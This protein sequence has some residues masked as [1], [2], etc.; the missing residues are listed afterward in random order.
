[1]SVAELRDLFATPVVKVEIDLKISAQALID[2]AGNISGAGQSLDTHLFQR[3]AYEGLLHAV[4][5]YVTSFMRSVLGIDGEPLFTQAWLNRSVPGQGHHRHFHPNS[6][7]SGVFYVDV[8]EGA[9]II[10][11]RNEG[12]N[13]Y[14]MQPALLPEVTE[15]SGTS[16]E[17]DVMNGT[18]LLFPSYLWHSVPPNLADVDRWSLAFNCVT[19]RVI[20]SAA[21]LSELK[22]T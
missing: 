7:V 3:P 20:G 14:A 21:K 19:D 9:S 6:L 5:P 17:I 16:V 1:M 12:S 15:Y 18:L 11:H 4:T 13:H 2:A 8:P 10:F 22:T